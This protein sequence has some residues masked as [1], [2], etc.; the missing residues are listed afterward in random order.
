LIETADRGFRDRPIGVVDERKPA[1]PAGFTI[2]W[3]NNLGGFTG[4]G[5][6]LS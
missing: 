6:V 1:R 3:E 4:A 2:D 5:Q